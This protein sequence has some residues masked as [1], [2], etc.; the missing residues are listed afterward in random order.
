[1]KERCKLDRID[2]RILAHLQ[3]NSRITNVQL[4]DA[5]GLSASPCLIRV[6]R[7]EKAGFILGYGAHIQLDKI[8]VVQTVFT[9]VTLSDHRREDFAR[10]ENH[11][12][13]ID[14]VMECHLMSGGY[15]YLLKFITHGVAEY[16]VLMEQMLESKVGIEKYFS[17]LVIKT[18]VVK[19]SYPVETLLDNAS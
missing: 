6:K 8:G 18:A 13:R 7:L 12:R 5:V 4:A 2:L 16:Q 10:F 14:Q 1:M 15:D 3:K 17:Y 11:I 9:E 19:H